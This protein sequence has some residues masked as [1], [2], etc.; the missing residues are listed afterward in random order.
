MPFHKEMLPEAQSY[1]EGRGLPLVGPKSSPWRTTRCEFHGGSDS[2]RL[3]VREGFWKCMSCDRKGDSVLSYEMA[4]TG[5]DFVEAAKAL[6]AWTDN[7]NAQATARR[8]PILS[9]RDSLAVIQQEM[10]IIVVT[11]GNVRFGVTLT[12]DDYSRVLLAGNRILTFVEE[13]T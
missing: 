10:L 1:F 2:M 4:I 11:A 9:L 12:D 5:S 6:G 13:A 8:K 7:P 3:N